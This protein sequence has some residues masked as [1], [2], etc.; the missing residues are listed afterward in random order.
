MKKHVLMT[1]AVAALG[2]P[3]LVAAQATAPKKVGGSI[4]LGFV[5]SSGNSEVQTFSLGQKFAWTP[6]PRVK[7]AQTARSVY[8]KADSVVNANLL[9]IEASLDYK[10]IDGLGLTAHQRVVKIIQYH[11]T[12]LVY[13]NYTIKK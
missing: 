6:A 1:A 8:G 5:S 13:H 10:L 3:S 12:K 7:F 4:D 9:S 11:N 2:A